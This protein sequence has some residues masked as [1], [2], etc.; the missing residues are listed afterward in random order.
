MADLD[1]TDPQHLADILQAAL[2]GFDD[3]TPD[4]VAPLVE[5]LE[6]S[7]SEVFSHVGTGQKVDDDEPVEAPKPDPEPPVEQV[8]PPPKQE[9]PNEIEDEILDEIPQGQ[10]PE[11]LAPPKK[12]QPNEISEGQGP[13]QLAPPDDNIPLEAMPDDMPQAQGPE[14]FGLEQ[15]E[16]PLD[17]GGE[18]QWIDDEPQAATEIAGIPIRARRGWNEFD[19]NRAKGRHEIYKLAASHKR[20]RPIKSE[21]TGK[22]QSVR[23][24]LPATKASS[25]AFIGTWL[26]TVEAKDHLVFS[27]AEVEDTY[28]RTFS[29][30]YDL[31]RVDLI[32]GA[33]FRGRRFSP[34][35]I[36]LA[37][38][39]D[40]PT[41]KPIFYM[42]EGGSAAGKP[43]AL[44]VSRR[45]DTEIHTKADFKFTPFACAANWYSGGLAMSQDLSEPACVYLDAAQT[46]SGAREYLKLSVIYERDTRMKR[47]V[48]PFEL[49]IEAAMRVMAI[50]DEIGCQ[51]ETGNGGVLQH[52]LG[53]IARALMPWDERPNG[54]TTPAERDAYC[55]CPKLS[56]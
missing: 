53:P 17:M 22:C 38:G 10:G 46:Q 45:M 50:A 33:R 40:A 36:Y 20:G 5:A 55:G 13:E 31:K 32:T 29:H 28:E 48:H 4:R 8:D 30:R 3:E 15:A 56:R 47:V 25:D 23:V 42:L 21:F 18:G 9:Q 27:I 7:D 43:E 26:G 24:R 35:S 1:L 19:R 49:Q 41:A 12:E 6:R 2:P 14:Q 54:T 34:V 44:Y 37:Y 39:S 51:L 52:S 11:Q 16:L